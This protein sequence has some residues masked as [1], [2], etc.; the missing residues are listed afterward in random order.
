MGLILYPSTMQASGCAASPHRAT[1]PPSRL[2]VALPLLPSWHGKTLHMGGTALNLLHIYM[3]A[4]VKDTHSQVNNPSLPCSWT[5]VC[6]AGGRTQHTV[7]KNAWPAAVSATPRYLLPTLADN[8]T[9]ILL[10]SAV[11][12]HTLPPARLLLLRY[13]PT[14]CHRW[15]GDS[16]R[17]AGI[18]NCL[19][20]AGSNDSGMTRGGGQ[21]K[22][23]GDHT[24][25]WRGIPGGQAFTSPCANVSRDAGSAFP[26]IFAGG[27][28]PHGL[29]LV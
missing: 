20:V 27:Y 16:T 17:R 24:L 12:L 15:R 10:L 29:R 9:F 19:M 7:A 8:L 2:P 22:T 25:P 6:I 21:A 28:C 23:A 5:N 14:T 18:A 4:G 26:N 13:L 3:G 11:A 1:F